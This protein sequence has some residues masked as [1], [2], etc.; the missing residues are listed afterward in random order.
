MNPRV[1]LR[2]RHSPTSKADNNYMGLF[3]GLGFGRHD[4]LPRE[5][6]KFRRMDSY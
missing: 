1:E 6:F 2:K 5:E 3:K 4:L